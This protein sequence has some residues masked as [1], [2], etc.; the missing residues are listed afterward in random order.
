MLRQLQSNDEAPNQDTQRAASTG[1]PEASAI[2]AVSSGH[3]DSAADA[4]LQRL[5]DLL[6]SRQKERRD[7]LSKHDKENLSPLVGG[8]MSPREIETLLA[9]PEVTSLHR[10]CVL[11]SSRTGSVR[12]ATASRD[13]TRES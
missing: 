3:A 5:C 7:K 1:M 6:H 2:I 12:G 9:S 13:G 8:N 4:R 11:T 10:C